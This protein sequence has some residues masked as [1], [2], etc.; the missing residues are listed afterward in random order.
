MVG[1]STSLQQEAQFF[2][3]FQKY[4]QGLLDLLR[5]GPIGLD[6]LSLIAV[7]GG[8][9]GRLGFYG[10]RACTGGPCPQLPGLASDLLW[11]FGQVS[12][13]LGF[14]FLA[15]VMKGLGQGPKPGLLK[16]ECVSN[17]LGISL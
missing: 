7:G 6:Q 3:F 17:A 8:G 14:S 4:L 2:F 10:K 13:S 9:R 11:H 16:S 1:R 12:V 5:D 15:C